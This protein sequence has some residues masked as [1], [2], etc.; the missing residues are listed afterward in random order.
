MQLHRHNKLVGE[1]SLI[2]TP[3]HFNYK[4]TSDTDCKELL[5]VRSY[6]YIKVPFCFIYNFCIFR[7][8]K[9]PLEFPPPMKHSLLV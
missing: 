9:Q 7:K 2:K 6:N 8:S 5:E 3:V 1:E 4:L